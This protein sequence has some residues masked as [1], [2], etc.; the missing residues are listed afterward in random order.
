MKWYDRLIV[1]LAFIVIGLSTG[2]IWTTS[3]FIEQVGRL[4]AEKKMLVSELAK[5]ETQ[6]GIFEGKGRRKP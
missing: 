2:F 6:K 3:Y 5:Y 4:K 1:Y